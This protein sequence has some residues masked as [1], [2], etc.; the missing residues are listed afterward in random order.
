MTKSISDDM[1]ESEKTKASLEAMAKMKQ[2]EED[3]KTPSHVVDEESLDPSEQ[4]GRTA[5]VMNEGEE[6]VVDMVNN[7][8]PGSA[9]AKKADPFI[10]KEDKEIAD[11][12]SSKADPF[13]E[14]D[15]KSAKDDDEYVD[16]F[17][18]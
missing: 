3:S 6:Q 17:I 4:M 15:G 7:A 8:T 10:D 12:S 2:E 5:I 13:V 1:A 16:A 9:K 18:E 11:A 14:G